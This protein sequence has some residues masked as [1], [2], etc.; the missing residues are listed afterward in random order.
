[1]RLTE[2]FKEAIEARDILLNEELNKSIEEAIEAIITSLRDGNKVLVAG[3]GGSASDAQ[4]FT[5]ELVGRFLKER[6]A[7]PAIA[8]S[9]NTSILTAI[10][11]DYSFEKIFSRQVE[12]LGIKGDVFIAIS[13]SGNAKNLIEGV[14]V[15]KRLSIKTIGLL[16]NDGGKLGKLVDIPIIVPLSKTPRIQ[17]IHEIIIHTM[18]EI[19]EEVLS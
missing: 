14:E 3:N 12:A 5:G 10:G 7:L 4:H 19:V 17:E 16:G 18:C 1:M 11:N 2:I 13:T 6:R 8:L 9:T 15:A